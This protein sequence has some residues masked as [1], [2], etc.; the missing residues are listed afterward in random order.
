MMAGE[1]LRA[2]LAVDS[3]ILPLLSVYFWQ[4]KSEGAAQ[5]LV[6]SVLAVGISV[7]TLTLW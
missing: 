7:R 3:F 5:G 4:K 6:S 2:G 1:S